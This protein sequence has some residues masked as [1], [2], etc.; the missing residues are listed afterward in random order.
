MIGTA[1]DFVRSVARAFTWQKVLLAE[2]LFVLLDVF[3]VL[4]FVDQFSVPQSFMWSRIVIEQTIA[5]SI[6]L[7][8]LAADEAVARGA[9]RF[10][11]YAIAIV[12][13]SAFA[14]TAQFHVRGWLGLYTIGDR[15]E[16]ATAARRMQMVYVGCDTLTYGV[17]FMLAWLEYRRRAEL[18]RRVRFAALARARTRPRGAETRLAALRS[19]VDA[20]ALLTTLEN[21]RDRF[22][23]DDPAA[24]E[25][26][27]EVIAG[28]RAKLAPAETA[29]SETRRDETVRGEMVRAETVRSDPVRSETGR[30]E[31][32][33]ETACDE[34]GRNETRRPGVPA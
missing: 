17:L 23:R 8:V 19:N 10:R 14:A 29:R 12:V 28:F 22:E 7:A 24:E 11:A 31:T 3:A 5:L 20:E 27:D 1:I 33:R 15:P 9:K 13:A 2:L 21:V 4:L 26:L 16:A 25:L 18:L 6:L 32:G 30:A 34:K